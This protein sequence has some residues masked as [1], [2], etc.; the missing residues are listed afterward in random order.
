MHPN[1]GRYIDFL[2]KV[3]AE[4]KAP[5]VLIHSA[6][7]I[8]GNRVCPLTFAFQGA[9]GPGIMKN[10]I[11]GTLP[12]AEVDDVTELYDTWAGDRA[13]WE[14][15]EPHTLPGSEAISLFLQAFRYY[16]EPG[17]AGPGGVR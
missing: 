16:A 5:G 15:G 14:G 2:S 17:E 3:Q 4:G 8:A 13:G 6:F 10:E 9:H 1:W 7:L 11:Y 12:S